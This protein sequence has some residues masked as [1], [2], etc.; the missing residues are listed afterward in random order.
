M[1]QILTA[2]AMQPL[3]K[4]MVRLN[5]LYLPEERSLRVL[6]DDFQDIQFDRVSPEDLITGS[7]QDLDIILDVAQ[8]EPVSRQFKLMRA[9]DMLQSF[10]AI[11]LPPNH[12]VVEYI[13]SELLRAYGKDRPELLLKAPETRQIAAQA[14]A[15]QGPA[16][17]NIGSLAQQLGVDQGPEV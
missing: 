6:G 8:T 1:F 17:D 15:A 5:E 2:Q 12:P 14:A 16:G 3:G 9:K 11:G 13:L 7:G 10:G 4:L